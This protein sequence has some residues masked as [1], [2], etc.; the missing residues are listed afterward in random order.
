MKPRFK[1][2]IAALVTATM[3]PA[4]LGRPPRGQAAKQVR[5]NLPPIQL[6]F[7]DEH[8]T[9]G[10][11]ATGKR[12]IFTEGDPRYKIEPPGL[13]GLPFIGGTVDGHPDPRLTNPNAVCGHGIVSDV[14]FPDEPSRPLSIQPITEPI[15]PDAPSPPAGDARRVIREQLPQLDR[16]EGDRMAAVREL[17]VAVHLADA[18]KAMRNLPKRVAK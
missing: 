1:L 14:A 3:A 6:E 16:P 17:R 18:A 5:R 7:T 2:V 8:P 15:D 11:G 10:P 13:C 4:A 12:I 9:G